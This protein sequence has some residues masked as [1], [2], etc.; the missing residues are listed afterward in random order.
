MTVPTQKYTT[1][2]IE[3]HIAAS[4]NMLITLRIFTPQLMKKFRIYTLSI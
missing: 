2:S 1:A 4:L 3:I